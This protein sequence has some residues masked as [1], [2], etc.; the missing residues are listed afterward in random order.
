MLPLWPWRGKGGGTGAAR[1]A[2]RVPAD[3]VPRIPVRS[4]T[5]ARNS[6]LTPV[7]RWVSFSGSRT[8][9]SQAAEPTP[10]ARRP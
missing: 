9:R 6:L 5:G 10:G 1:A 7:A 2:R 8:N 4:R 3:R